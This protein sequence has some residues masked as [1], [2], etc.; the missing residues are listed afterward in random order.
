MNFETQE[1]KRITVK[2]PLI[3]LFQRGKPSSP[4]FVKGR[5]GGI[6][7]TLNCYKNSNFIRKGRATKGLWETGVRI[8]F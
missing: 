3:P 8:A 7:K 5:M 6:F 2:S 1:I 4:P